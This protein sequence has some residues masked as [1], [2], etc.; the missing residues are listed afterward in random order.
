MKIKDYVKNALETKFFKIPEVNKYMVHP[1][2][3]DYIREN[4]DMWIESGI[5]AMFLMKKDEEYVIREGKIKIIDK[6]NTGNLQENMQ[7][8]NGLH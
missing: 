3:M 6:E 2:K 7:Y 4:L 8:S 5:K 1:Y